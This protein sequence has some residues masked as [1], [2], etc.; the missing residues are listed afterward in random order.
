ME[1]VM[2]FGK[3]WW[4]A[5]I[6]MYHR[7]DPLLMGAAI[8]YNSLFALVPLAA[9]FVAIVALFDFSDSAFS[10]FVDFLYTA[11][12]VEVAAFLESLLD[13][14]VESLASDQLLIAVVSILIAL[15]SGSRAVYAIQKSLRL[16][17]GVPDDRGYLKTRG[18]G[19]GVTIAAGASVML[20]YAVLLLG[21]TAWEAIADFLRL[22]DV[23]TVQIIL[24]VLVF[25]WMFGLLYI[26]YRFGPPTPVDFPAIT[27]GIVTAVLIVGSRLAV[28]LAP[29]FSSDALAVF[30]TVGVLLIWLYALGVVVVSVPMAVGAT[31]AALADLA[32]LRQG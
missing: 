29:S 23:G 21:E 20:G 18:T 12:P 22:P 8:A 17:Q 25:A 10:R 9:A 5:G 15:W 6:V 19:L 31:R 32:E 11:L 7:G 1:R 2:Q 16:V 28:A 26:I 30:G 14:P 24:S 4:G 27:A 13:Q 3:S